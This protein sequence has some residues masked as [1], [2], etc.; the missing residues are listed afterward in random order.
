MAEVS[1]FP[2]IGQELAPWRFV[3]VGAPGCCGFV[4]PVPSATLDKCPLASSELRQRRS[5]RLPVSR[6]CVAYGL[7]SGLRCSDAGSSRG[8]MMVAMNQ[9]RVFA[10]IVFV[11]FQTTA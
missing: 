7:I 4:G 5:G 10:A 3:Q 8:I 6:P 2:F 9:F 11:A 1:S